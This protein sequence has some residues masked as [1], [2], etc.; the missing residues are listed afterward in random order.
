M[1]AFLSFVFCLATTGQYSWLVYTKRSLPAAGAGEKPS[2]ET[3]ILR[4]PVADLATIALALNAKSEEDPSWFLTVDGGAIINALSDIG[5]SPLQCRVKFL[6]QSMDRVYLLNLPTDEGGVPFKVL[7]GHNPESWALKV[8]LDAHRFSQEAT[9]LQKVAASEL[10]PGFYALG[11]SPPPSG[12]AMWFNEAVPSAISFVKTVKN[13]NEEGWWSS[14]YKCN[15]AGVIVM[16]MAAEV[17]PAAERKDI[18]SGVERTLKAAHAVSVVHTDIR[19]SNILYFDV[20]VL[21]DENSGEGWQLI[22]FGLSADAGS[23]VVI[24][25]DSSRGRRCGTRIRELLKNGENSVRC[26]W[27]KADDIEMLSALEL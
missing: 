19:R 15:G 18:V 10:V 20:V 7:P 4:V 9:A 24:S 1:S 21:D 16:R 23:S 25:G 12:D 2:F 26:A 22:D 3:R 8:V 11:S 17:Q 13:V 6:E 27:N 5:V 14:K